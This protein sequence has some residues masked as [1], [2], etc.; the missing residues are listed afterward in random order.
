MSLA[1]AREACE[2]AMGGA[3]RCYGSYENDDIIGFLVV[4]AGPPAPMEKVERRVDALDDLVRV[5]REM[6]ETYAA[7]TLAAANQHH[8]DE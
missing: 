6:G 8:Q 4:P 5:A 7:R 1:E 2:S 3:G